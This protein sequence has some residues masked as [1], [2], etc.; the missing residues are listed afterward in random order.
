MDTNKYAH[1]AALY[2]RVET[3]DGEMRTSLAKAR[4]APMKPT[5]VPRLELQADVMGSRIA[6]A[7]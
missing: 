2:W 5:S 3:P 1:D 6:A 7:V 4:V